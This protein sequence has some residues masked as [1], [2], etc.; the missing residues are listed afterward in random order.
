MFNWIDIQVQ[1]E[2]YRDYVRRAEHERLVRRLPARRA[3][4]DRLYDRLLA[5]LGSLLIA[6]G[7]HLQERHGDAARLDLYGLLAHA[8]DDGRHPGAAC[9]VGHSVLPNVG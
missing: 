5:L 2:R 6:A 7:R 1:H 4:A 9:P 8:T 3:K